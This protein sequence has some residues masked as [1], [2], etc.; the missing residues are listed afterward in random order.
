MSSNFARLAGLARNAVDKVLGEPAIL[1]PF[2]RARGPHGRL[3]AS[4]TRPEVE[5]TAVFY[6]DTER[7]AR[8]RAQPLVSR[9]GDRLMNRTPEIFASV[10]TAAEIATGDRIVRT[11]TGATYQV[12]T[13]DPD[14]NGNIILGLS[15][16][17]G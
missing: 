12:E 1:K 13:R 4:D 14:G 15:A 5:I 3:S 9:S 2:D 17:K 10:S 11:G 7:A 6:Q 16:A 8:E